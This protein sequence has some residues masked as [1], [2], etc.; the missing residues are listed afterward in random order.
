M[1]EKVVGYIDDAM[2][3]VAERNTTGKGGEKIQ[4]VSLL[5]IGELIIT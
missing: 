2:A 3:L 1:L 5:S 4:T